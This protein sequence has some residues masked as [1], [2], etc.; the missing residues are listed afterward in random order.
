[1]EIKRSVSIS[2]DTCYCSH[3]S[4][5]FTDPEGNEVF[6][7]VTDEQYLEI[8]ARLDRK[9]SY[10][11]NQRKSDLEEQISKLKEDKENEDVIDL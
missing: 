9:A 3:S 4:M 11:E 1:L 2:Y 6:I 7:K 10:I 8:A 5:N